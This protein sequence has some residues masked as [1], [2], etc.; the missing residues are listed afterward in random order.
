[1]A[2]Q[3]AA[4]LGVAMVLGVAA[5]P[6]AAGTYPMRQCASA[7]SKAVTGWSSYGRGGFY[8][9]CDSTGLFGFRADTMKYNSVAGISLL[10]G[11][12]TSHITIASIDGS[13][14][15]AQEIDEYS[16]VRWYATT[17]GDQ[18]LFEA[19]L[20]PF[21]GNFSL[22]PPPGT[23]SMKID[24]YC[25]Y[26]KGAVD[27]N[28]DDPP[29]VIN[30]S[31]LVYMLAEGVKPDGQVTGGGLLDNGPRSGTQ[32]LGYSAGDDDSGVKTV[33]AK[34]GST[35][36]AT[37]DLSVSCAYDNWNACPRA[38]SQTLTVDTSQLDD[39]RYP[40]TLEVADAA[41][42]AKTEDTGRT[43]TV[44]NGRGPGDANGTGACSQCVLSV[45]AGHSGTD[46]AVKV[47]HKDTVPVVGRLTGADGQP[48]GGATVDVLN[49]AGREGTVT[50]G[51]DG[52]FIF[53]A[54]PGA[55]RHLTFAYRA[56]ANDQGYAVTG[57]VFIRVKDAVR[58]RATPKHPR[59]GRKVMIEGRLTG[60]PG[61]ASEGVLVTLQGK[62]AGGRRWRTF[63][64]TRADANGYFVTYY[65][66]ERA[67]PGQR[68]AMRARATP[69][70]GFPFP[71]DY[72]R[73]VKVSVR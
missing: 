20:T 60:V 35:T 24:V 68:F 2:M 16:F 59:R 36:V 3:G 64:T 15:T 58:V 45:G 61:S 51:S 6:A 31:S 28:F 47:K 7:P 17:F 14:S 9:E 34:L 46:P 57:M 12:G 54:Q 33:V 63:G 8:D 62:A 69:Q 4:V 37:D 55:S 70:A 65:R 11:G 44:K 52:A 27:C 41:G 43:I 56:H 39:G 48:V 32:T 18:L 53:V 22:I 40:L 25:S 26:G 21:S 42:N 23:R 30:V 50:T 49:D 29:H 38:H 19:E 10:V 67:S 66:F 1:M 72:S 73:A 5:A 13:M 71:T